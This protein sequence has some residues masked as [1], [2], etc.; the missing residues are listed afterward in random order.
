MKTP[1]P[2][3]PQRTDP[4]PPTE[5]PHH[6]P[7]KL[8]IIAILLALGALVGV[9]GY[10]TIRIPKNIETWPTPVPQE[11]IPPSP[12]ADD[13]SDWETYRN[14]EY[15]F[16]FQ[17][18]S[19]LYINS[20]LNNQS[21]TDDIVTLTSQDFQLISGGTEDGAVQQGFMLR[22]SEVDDPSF[23]KDNFISDRCSFATNYSICEHRTIDGYSSVFLSNENTNSATL[24]VKKENVIYD[25]EIR[26]SPYETEQEYERLFGQ[27][28][29][30]FRFLD[31][32]QDTIQ[33]E[34]GNAYLIQEDEQQLLADK[35]DFKEASYAP[36]ITFTDALISPDQ[37]KILL[38]A[39]G[40]ISA[41][42]LFYSDLN[43]ISF[44]Y[45]N[46]VSQAMWSH[47]S[48]YVAFTSTIADAGGNY[49]LGIY[50]T[51]SHQTVD[52]SEQSSIR[53]IP[54]YSN[55]RWQED[56][57]GII[58]HYMAQDEIPYGKKVGEGDITIPV[59][60]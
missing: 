33:I 4:A 35:N 49:Y 12:V 48:Q 13:L 47:N 40:G 6:K 1:Q 20:Q 14:E 17:Y 42:L 59:I 22:M 30:T 39:Q 45:I 41:N 26:F 27:I 31:N 34:N 54:S 50:D 51:N 3:S 16:E 60:L 46:T 2:P 37:R 57:S 36:P 56:D 11:S 29:S 8:I 15:G 38:I 10:Q 19:Y 25:L 5:P 44:K 24:F 58:V 43:N 18:P 52:V 55:I 32:S 23:N 7:I 28:L 21:L 9:I 53:G